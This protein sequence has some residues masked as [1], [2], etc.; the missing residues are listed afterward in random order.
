MEGKYLMVDGVHVPF[1]VDAP[2]F[3]AYIFLVPFV[4]VSAPE[5]VLDKKGFPVAV[6]EQRLGT[7]DDSSSCLT[8]LMFFLA[9]LLM[10]ICLYEFFSVLM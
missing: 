5:I 6:P 10:I 7:G 4:N 1:S 2:R 3:V 8:D 9:L